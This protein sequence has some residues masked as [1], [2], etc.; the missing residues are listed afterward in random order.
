MKL[1]IPSQI[2]RCFSIS[3]FIVSTFYY[4]SNHNI[5]LGETKAMILEKSKHLII[6]NEESIKALL[7]FTIY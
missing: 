3:T 2:I 5:Y 7:D 6:G 4:V 1:L